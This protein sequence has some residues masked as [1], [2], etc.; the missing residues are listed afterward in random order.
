MQKVHTR[1][2]LV[3]LLTVT[4][5]LA[6]RAVVQ[7][8]PANPVVIPF[9]LGTRHIFVKATVNGSRPLSFIFDTGANQALLRLDV[10]KELN[11]RLE[12]EVRSGGA[13]PGTQVGSQV[14]KANWSL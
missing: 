4:W 2:L 11:L 1:L 12:G 10:A 14:R 3:V 13:G 6:P 9:E 7:R 5:G 8:S